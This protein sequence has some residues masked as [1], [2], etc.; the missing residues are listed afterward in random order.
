MSFCR[1]AVRCRARTEEKLRLVQTEFKMPHL[2]TDA[3]IEEILTVLPDFTKWV[4]EITAYA[5]DAAVNH[6]E[7]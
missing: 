2:L 1:A 6:G 7:M 5:T 4:N 3:E